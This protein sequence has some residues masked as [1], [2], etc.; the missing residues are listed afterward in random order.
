MTL[1]H[2]GYNLRDFGHSKVFYEKALAPLAI[3]VLVEGDGWAMMGRDGKPQFWFGAP[4]KRAR[5]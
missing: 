4:S 3:A 1:D 2:I 5:G